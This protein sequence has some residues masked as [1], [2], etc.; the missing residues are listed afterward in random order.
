M[1]KFS[2]ID[3]NRSDNDIS[4]GASNTNTILQCFSNCYRDL[5]QKM[6]SLKGFENRAKASILGCI[7]AGNYSSFELQRSHLAYVHEELVGPIQDW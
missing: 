1:E 3:P 5:Q 7:L 6:A 2:I 4:G